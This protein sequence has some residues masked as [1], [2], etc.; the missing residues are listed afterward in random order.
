MCCP[1]WLLLAPSICDVGRVSGLCC[2]WRLLDW[3]WC[4][5]ALVRIVLKLGHVDTVQ[6]GVYCR[7]ATDEEA[8]RLANDTEYGLAAY[9]FSRGLAR[10]WH[11]AAE[12][13]YGMIG[14]NETAIVSEMALFEG[15]KQSRLGRDNGPTGIDEFRRR[16]SF[17]WP[18]GEAC[19]HIECQLGDDR[20]L[21]VPC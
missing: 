13:E 9:F 10:V 11:V 4:C 5:T 2:S 15:V 3:Q 17:A 21:L 20:L 16:R 12:L 19:K 7:F 1:V 14:V 18:Q 8:I 6:P